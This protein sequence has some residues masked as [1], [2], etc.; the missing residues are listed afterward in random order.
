MGTGTYI[1]ERVIEG[2]EDAVGE[3]ALVELLVAQ[4]GDE[5][6]VAREER[7]AL[8]KQRVGRHRNGI[9]NGFR[10]D[11]W[12]PAVDTDGVDCALEDVGVRV[13]FALERLE[14]RRGKRQRE[15]HRCRASEGTASAPMIASAAAARC[16]IRARVEMCNLGVG[17]GGA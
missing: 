9:Q 10:C 1:P 17:R 15:A 5:D 3:R 11:K 6:V 2:D 12:Y 14:P 7:D 13:R 16:A 8:R 4:H